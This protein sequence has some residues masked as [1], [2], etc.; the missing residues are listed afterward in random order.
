MVRCSILMLT[1]HNLKIHHP[2]PHASLAPLEHEAVANT[3]SSTDFQ[4]RSLDFL[5]ASEATASDKM[6]SAAQDAVAKGRTMGFLDGAIHRVTEEAHPSLADPGLPKSELQR[7]LAGIH[8]WQECLQALSH[9][10][11]VTRLPKDYLS[12]VKSIMT[13]YHTFCASAHAWGDTDPELLRLLPQQDSTLRQCDNLANLVKDPVGAVLSHIPVHKLP[14]GLHIGTLVGRYAYPAV[15]VGAKLVGPVTTVVLGATAKVPVAVDAALYPLKA[16]AVVSTG[17]AA[18]TLMLMQ[19][20][21][22]LTGVLRRQPTIQALSQLGQIWGGNCACHDDLAAV[23]NILESKA[24]DFGLKSTVVLA[25]LVAAYRLE[26]SIKHHYQ[27]KADPQSSPKRHVLQNLLRAA[28]TSPPDPSVHDPQAWDA[29]WQTPDRLE[30]GHL[31]CD[32]AVAIIAAL[33][34]DGD[35]TRGGLK[36]V[37]AIASFNGDPEGSIDAL[38]RRLE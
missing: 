19:P 4:G 6:R 28:Q 8:A 20:V 15:G 36:A 25:P 34:G 35:V 21:T 12:L 11:D 29:W 2:T 9:D 26:Q 22:A 30:A 14:L 10:P 3:S 32:L 31:D 37:A 33:F 7:Q 38:R 5:P 23:I 17:I 1:M 18:Q 27:H 24:T 16:L 13:L